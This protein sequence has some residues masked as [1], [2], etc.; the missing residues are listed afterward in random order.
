MQTLITC[1]IDNLKCFHEALSPRTEKILLLRKAKEAQ[2]SVN[3]GKI[4]KK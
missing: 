1:D 4:G 3:R 2:N